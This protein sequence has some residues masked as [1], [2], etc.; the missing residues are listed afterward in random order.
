[1]RSVAVLGTCLPFAEAFSYLFRGA[2]FL[3]LQ[4]GKDGSDCVVYGEIRIRFTGGAVL[5]KRPGHIHDEGD[6]KLLNR[7]ERYATENIL[8]G[9][10]LLQSC[11]C[12][13]CLLDVPDGGGALPPWPFPIGLCSNEKCL[14]PSLHIRQKLL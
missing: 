14:K 12:L 6:G 13:E 10:N 9:D 7:C 8:R 4:L 3:N 1:M 5:G 11:Q 2:V